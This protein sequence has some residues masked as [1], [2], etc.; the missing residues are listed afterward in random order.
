MKNIE[1]IDQQI[2]NVEEMNFE[3]IEGDKKMLRYETKFLPQEDDMNIYEQSFENSMPSLY[4]KN[5]KKNDLDFEEFISKGNGSFNSVF[6]AKS[7]EDFFGQLPDFYNP[8]RT[9]ATKI[10]AEGDSISM[11]Q[12]DAIIAGVN[13]KNNNTLGSQK[14]DF[15]LIK[16][17]HLYAKLDIPRS[18][19][20]SVEN[21]QEYLKPR[22]GMQL[23]KIERN[24]FLYGRGQDDILGIFT[25][26]KLQIKNEDCD[27]K[28][29]N[30]FADKLLDL[31]YAIS[32]EYKHEAC[33]MLSSEMQ[34]MLAKIKD[35]QDRYIFDNKTLFGFPVYTLD[36]LRIDASSAA[37]AAQAAAKN[38]D[39]IL[40]G[41]F[42]YGYVVSDKRN[43]E[44]KIL[45]DPNRPSTQSLILSNTCGAGIVCPDAIHGMIVTVK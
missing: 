14:V 17:S 40:F 11:P 22:L 21:R 19:L 12:I 29:L 2:E 7:V 35:K 45:D 8:L 30:E 36:E 43:L 15:I 37:A 34:K 18:F 32:S 26:N 13:N 38:Q 16:H 20:Q 25:D 1:N 39:K 4:A 41:N 28:K 23:S 31:T 27:T 9:L 24:E 6:S 3:K 33:F 5:N 42:K 10:T 44:L